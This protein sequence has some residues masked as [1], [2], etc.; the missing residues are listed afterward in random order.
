MC[1]DHI[2]YSN[3]ESDIAS[4]SSLAVPEI[5]EK[6]RNEVNV[7]TIPTLCRDNL[8]PDVLSLTSIH[9]CTV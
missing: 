1:H 7:P 2:V 3:A 4:H 6:S 9:S 8:S 5:S